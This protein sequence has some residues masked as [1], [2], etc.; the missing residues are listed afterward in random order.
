V[1]AAATAGDDDE[2]GCHDR[3]NDHGDGRGLAAR[4]GDARA[5]RRLTAH[6]VVL[7]N[8]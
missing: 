3:K 6:A 7:H 8:G 5:R 4:S 2:R 1:I